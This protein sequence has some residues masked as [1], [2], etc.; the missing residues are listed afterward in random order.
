MLLGFD[1]YWLKRGLNQS[2][3]NLISVKITQK[4]NETKRD[5][6]KSCALVKCFRDVANVVRPCIIQHCYNLTTTSELHTYLVF[7]G[8]FVYMLLIWKYC[9]TKFYIPTV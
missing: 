7:N 9:S 6:F 8:N 5:E 2:V 1:L 3:W 4:S